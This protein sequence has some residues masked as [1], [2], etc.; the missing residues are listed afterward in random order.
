LK[1]RVEPAFG[2]VVG[3]ADITADHGLLSANFTNLGHNR[4]SVFL[5]NLKIE[6]K[7]PKP[8]FCFTGDRKVTKNSFLVIL[9]PNLHI[10]RKI[11]RV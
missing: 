9:K 8:V 6:A 3:M 1:V 2:D 10:Y 4:I 11:N 7:L 5:R